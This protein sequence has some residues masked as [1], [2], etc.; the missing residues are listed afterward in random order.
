MSGSDAFLQDFFLKELCSKFLDES[1]ERIHYSIEIDSPKDF[2]SDLYNQS[3][4]SSKRI[5]FVRDI[6]KIKSHT[7]ELKKYIKSPDSNNSVIFINEEYSSKSKVFNDIIKSSVSVNVS[8]PFENKIKEWIGYILKLKG[9]KINS[10]DLNKLIEVYGD[11]IGSVINEIEKIYILNGGKSELNLN[12]YSLVDKSD[13][14]YFLWNILDHL[15]YKRL[16]N[17]LI[18]YQSLINHGYSNIQILIKLYQFFDFISNN[19]LNKTNDK[20]SFMFNK[21]IIN[22]LG[23]YMNKYTINE[24]DNILLELRNID[25]KLKTTSIKERLFFHPLFINICK[26]VYAKL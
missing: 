13:R 10:V 11:S 25:I 4:F 1:G 16:D 2:I 9:Y 24:L 26:G 18:V 17:T 14:E 23:T 7:D 21:I 22:R 6:H 19:K 3:L 8:P 20:Q 15:G 12:N 5:F